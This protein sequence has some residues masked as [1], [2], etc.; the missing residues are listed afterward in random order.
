MSLGGIL[1]AITA[2]LLPTLHA[3]TGGARFFI[4]TG[5]S[6]VL[7][8]ILCNSMFVFRVRWITEMENFPSDHGKII[9]TAL[10]IRSNKTRAYHIALAIMIIGLLCYLMSIYVL[11]LS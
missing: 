10:K 7:A 5:A 2:S 6:F 1:L 8:S 9:D 4:V 11:A 3:L